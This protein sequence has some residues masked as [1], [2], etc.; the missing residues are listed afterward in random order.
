M[1]PEVEATMLIKSVAVVR[2]QVISSEG[3][4][5]KDFNIEESNQKQDLNAHS[6]GATFSLAITSYNLD[7]YL[8]DLN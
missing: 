3:T 6:L 5:L 2:L 7:N 8:T 1:I 4:W